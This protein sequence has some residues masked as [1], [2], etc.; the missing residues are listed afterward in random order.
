MKNTVVTEVFNLV[1]VFEVGIGVLLW[2]VG[3]TDVR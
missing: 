2:P 3:D 1:N